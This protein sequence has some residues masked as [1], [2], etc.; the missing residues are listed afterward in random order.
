MHLVDSLRSDAARTL[1][2]GR[3]ETARSPLVRRQG[4]GLWTLR[5]S[6][7]DS[8]KRPQPL[9]LLRAEDNWEKDPELVTHDPGLKC[10]L[11]PR[12]YKGSALV[13]PGLLGGFQTQYARS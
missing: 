5:K 7:C 2:P 3:G 8:R 4:T 1:P 6:L 9:L 12:P 10:Y 13:A 11:S